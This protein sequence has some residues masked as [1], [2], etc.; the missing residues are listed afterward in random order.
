MKNLLLILF[1]TISQLVFSQ[2][3]T[4][5]W[6][7]GYNAGVNFNNLK[8]KSLTNGKIDTN[9]GC[10]TISDKNGH[11]LFYTDGV[12]VWDSTFNIMP[13]GKG[14]KGNSTTTQSAI[15]IPR[16]DSSHLFYIFTL[17]YEGNSNGC[18]YSELNMNLNSGHGDIVSGKKNIFLFGPSCE[19][20]CATKH[21]NG[22]DIWIVAHKYNS[23]SIFAYQ[24][25]SSGINVIPSKSTSGLK[26]TN[27]KENT[28]G[29]MKIS[30]DGKK[31]AF[32]NYYSATSFYNII[33]DFDV[34]TGKVTNFWTFT[35]IF[36]YG[37][38][39]SPKSKYI[40]IA[41]WDM[42]ENKSIYQYDAKAS[43]KQEFIDSKKDIGIRMRKI[44]SLQLGIDDKI[45]F[46]INGSNYLNVIH[47]PDSL[48]TDCR[49]QKLF[50]Y[51]ASKNSTL[52]LP[53]FISSYFNPANIN[54]EGYCPNVATSFSVIYSDKLDS[55]KWDFGDT[56]SGTN[57]FSNNTNYVYHTYKKPGKYKVSLIY[58]YNNLKKIVTQ[59]LKIKTPEKPF[60]GN[61]T[62]I[63]DGNTLIL[64]P[65]KS[66]KSY[67][68]NNKST[69]KTIKISDAGFFILISK[70]TA[71]CFSSDTIEIKKPFFAKPFIGK[72]TIM[73]NSFK[74]KLSPQQDYLSYE[75][76]NGSRTKS[77]NVVEKGI[78]S[79]W[80]KDSVGCYKADTIIVQNPFISVD[81]TISDTFQCFNNNSFV[82]KGTTTYKEDN[83]KKSIWYFSDGTSIIDTTVKKSFSNS[84][85]YTV[86]LV[87]QSQ[88]GCSDYKIRSVT[89]NPK[90]I[91]AY[92]T[93]DGCET[94]SI[95]FIN[96]SRFAETYNWKYG[97]GKYSTKFSPRHFYQIN[98]VS[99]T[100]NVTLVTILS[101]CSDSIV[102]S[103][104]IN[105]N[106]KSD[107]S[108]T[109]GNNKWNFT[110]TQPENTKYKWLFGD[111]DS[112]LS[113]NTSHIFNDGLPSH[114]VC[115]KVTNAAGCYTETCKQIV[116]TSISNT[117]PLGFKIY[118]NP[119]SGNFTIE[120]D[121]PEK[122]V[123]IEVYN[124]VGEMVERIERIG[125]ISNINL[126][127][128]VGIYLV[129]VKNGEVDY[130]QKMSI[131][132]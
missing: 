52:G 126:N 6:Y 26:I 61:D 93:K 72:D 21:K 118:P 35:G 12:S 33:A 82:F 32:A 108:Y 29:Q 31:I 81:F 79:L 69:T 71:G 16:P 15:I 13:N 30:P 3:E 34:S 10:A 88:L 112:S 103:V 94:D 63:C 25:T 100:Y 68:W 131:A 125:G 115:L 47:A 85:I 64:S 95:S 84:G 55:A 101:G 91:P 36:S 65:K 90:T 87:S 49:P 132:K 18:M 53:N 111:G 48:G 114:T 128:S 54:I 42:D 104:T 66:Y 102:K 39:F 56:S 23:D 98:G 43:S 127:V 74:L 99:Q 107:F 60:I 80:V 2:G 110:P 78:Y 20:I 58:Y 9:E 113:E 37:L 129:K 22:K 122:D 120:I 119:N 117:K 14:L 92:D 123:L 96:Q 105:A 45:Y 67:Y 97:D 51:L 24:I 124:M 83:H 17:D 27:E 46:A 76:S 62:N 121:N 11:L 7:F 130:N 89:V 41:Q 4:N 28:I 38:E 86:M 73:C 57:N 77:L 5:N 106:P 75:W 40:Y 70:D 116:T 50:L 8:V 59:D 1:L 109:L 44:A 19:K